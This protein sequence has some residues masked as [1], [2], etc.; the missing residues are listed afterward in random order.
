MNEGNNYG[1]WKAK[2][3]ETSEREHN[4]RNTSFWFGFMIGGFTGILLLLFFIS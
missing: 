2:Q 3:Q 1:K 4:R